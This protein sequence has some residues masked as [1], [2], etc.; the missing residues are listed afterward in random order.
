MFLERA[1]TPNFRALAEGLIKT[2]DE[3]SRLQREFPK[4]I[5]ANRASRKSKKT[6]T[7][8]TSRQ[9]EF[10]AEADKD[11]VAA[12]RCL[13]RSFRSIENERE[14]VQAALQC[15]RFDFKTWA[16]LYDSVHRDD[17]PMAQRIR[18]LQTKL[19]QDMEAFLA[20]PLETQHAQPLA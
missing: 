3:F 13:E 5:A 7:R 9:K 1:M 4:L 20:G 17:Q 10:F 15:E 2:S 6:P 12:N 18:S 19:I 11:A 16:W 8:Q 14:L